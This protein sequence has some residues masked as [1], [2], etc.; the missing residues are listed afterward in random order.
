M[1]A[2]DRSLAG[3]D[4][5][6]PRC[7]PF[8]RMH[9]NNGQNKHLV[10]QIRYTALFSRSVRASAQCKSDHME[11][12]LSAFLGE[13]ASR[14]MSF[15]IGKLSKYK[16]AEA[17]AYSLSSDEHLRRKLLRLRIIVDEAEGRQIRSQ[18]MLEQL[19]ILQA[20]VHTGH[21]ALDAF[22]YDQVHHQ[23][24]DDIVSLHSFAISKFN[25][26]KRI[27]L[28]RRSSSSGGGRSNSEA[29]E[30][31]LREVLGYLEIIITD[32]AEF[33]VFLKE[34]PPLHLHRRLYSTY[35]DLENCMFDCHV[36]MEYVINFVLAQ[37]N[38]PAGCSTEDRPDVLPIVGPAKSGKTTLVEH[39]CNDERVRR[40]FF[41]IVLFAED[42]LH[43]RVTTSVR[44]GG[45]RVKY[46]SQASRRGGRSVLVIV[47][48]NED[49]GEAAWSGLITICSASTSTRWAT[50]NGVT[51]III[52]SRSDKIVRFGTTSLLK[53][54]FLTQEAY[55]Y[56]FKALA[57][58]SMDPERRSQSS[59]HWQWRSPRA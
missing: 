14:S 15:F 28:R 44:G 45:G 2:L 31:K 4:P 40:A 20:G 30:K 43:E 50:T 36:E 32:A 48:V 42:D 46:Q 59:H 17:P 54:G 55:W 3:V 37:K 38:S 7:L 34:C 35:L 18:A 10:L 11:V 51:K 16:Q 57:F 23:G 26:A 8:V 41:Q 25:P 24:K 53:I 58:G 19:K 39:V 47:E 22:K 56:F 5:C 33:V 21:Y 49:I 12:A 1:R 6:L 52:C 29:G 9:H 13:V 27:Q